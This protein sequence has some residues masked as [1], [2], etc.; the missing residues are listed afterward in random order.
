MDSK[1]TASERGGGPWLGG[2]GLS[3]A[4]GLLR[5]WIL[6]LPF[7]VQGGHSVCQECTAW[8]AVR[9]VGQSP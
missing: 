6:P 3:G 9:R 7:R 1:R 5:G 2:A 8:L 4:R